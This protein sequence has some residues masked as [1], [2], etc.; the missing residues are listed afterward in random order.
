MAL[1][2]FSAVQLTCLKQMFASLL[3]SQPD[4]N[5]WRKW[6]LTHLYKPLWQGRP[7]SKESLKTATMEVITIWMF[8]RLIMSCSPSSINCSVTETC[9]RNWKHLMCML[10]IKYKNARFKSVFV[11]VP[12]Q[13]LFRM[14]SARHS[15]S[16][17]FCGCSVS[18]WVLVEAEIQE[19][20]L[21]KGCTAPS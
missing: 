3:P 13:V 9:C 10:G 18:Q 17:K 6:A 16:S 21:V 14:I 7:F 5:L 11:D 15:K 8:V 1:N 20:L 4:N 2:C 19:F 12:V